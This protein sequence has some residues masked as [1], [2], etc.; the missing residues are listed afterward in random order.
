LPTQPPEGARRVNALD[1]ETQVITAPLH[2]SVV[3]TK[4]R[5]GFSSPRL[6]NLAKPLW[7]SEEKAE[8]GA[9]VAVFGFGLRPEYRR[10]ARHY[11]STKHL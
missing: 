2:G 4:T 7:L 3:W 11:S 10:L 5:V 1:V 6:F 8:P 9:L